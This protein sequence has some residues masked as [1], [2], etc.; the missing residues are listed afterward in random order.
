[1]T[2]SCGSHPPSP[3]ALTNTCTETTG[4]CWEEH[5]VPSGISPEQPLRDPSPGII[6]G[7]TPE[8]GKAGLSPKEGQF[9]S[10]TSGWRRT[11][12]Q[13]PERLC[14][15]LLSSLRASMSCVLAK[16]E[17]PL[18]VLPSGNSYCSWELYPY[19]DFIVADEKEEQTETKMNQIM[20]QEIKKLATVGSIFQ[21]LF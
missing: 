18:T 5:L 2:H 6:P 10:L 1:M 14:R 21:R 20:L 15:A 9:T 17:T 16:S 13:D 11:K 12:T 19:P 4:K 3:A 8:V 7:E